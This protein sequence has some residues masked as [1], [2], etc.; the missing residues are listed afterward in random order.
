MR[1]LCLTVTAY[2]GVME[3][4]LWQQARGWLSVMCGLMQ[5]LGETVL[6]FK[7]KNV[8]LCMAG[9]SQQVLI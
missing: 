6:E 5:I 3:M 4:C 8:A 2:E 1:A 7:R 9:I